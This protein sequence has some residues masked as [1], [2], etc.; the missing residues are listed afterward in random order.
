MSYGGS[1]P[2]QLAL[3]ILA[4]HLGDD[5]KAMCLHDEFKSSVIVHVGRWGWI[6]SSG[7]IDRWL[8]GREGEQ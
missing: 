4:D 2:A 8:S 1:G 5:R 3:V 7:M 6:L